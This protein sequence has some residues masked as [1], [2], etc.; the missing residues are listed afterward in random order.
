MS[1]ALAPCPALR[2]DQLG[3]TKTEILVGLLWRAGGAT[4]EQ[5]VE[6]TG[7]GPCAV[8][9]SLAALMRRRQTLSVRSR[10]TPAGRFY[11]ISP[12]RETGDEADLAAQF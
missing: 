9:A 4:L 12:E 6:A 1:K 8:K 2:G 7:L 3:P 11:A 10:K 5:M